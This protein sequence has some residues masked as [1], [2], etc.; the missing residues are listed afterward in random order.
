M[1]G[2]A[3]T[4]THG[5]THTHTRTRKTILDTPLCLNACIC[6]CLP[7]LVR[8][9][10]CIFK[11]SIKI[12]ERFT[13]TKHHV[14]KSISDMSI[15]IFKIYVYV[16]G[17]TYVCDSYLSERTHTHPRPPL[18]PGLLPRSV[19]YCAIE[20]HIAFKGP[21]VILSNLIRNIKYNVH[22]ID[23]SD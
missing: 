1:N 13:F 21:P 11:K 23:L 10:K 3:S 15:L 12:P 16:R 5:R 22:S 19:L 2:N 7:A 6:A 8:S 18:N 17:K 4:H 20:Y 9:V 14:H